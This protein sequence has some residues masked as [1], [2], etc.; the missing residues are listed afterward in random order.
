[1]TRNAWWSPLGLSAALFVSCG[2]KAENSIGRRAGEAPSTSP[3]STPD[4]EGAASSGGAYGS[5]AGGSSSGGSFPTG[6]A[7]FAGGP[8][9]AGGHG[10]EPSTGGAGPEPATPPWEALYGHYDL[11][12]FPAGTWDG[13]TA[14]EQCEYPTLRHFSLRNGAS[15][16]EARLFAPYRWIGWPEIVTLGEGVLEVR[17]GEQNSIEDLFGELALA[18]PFDEN[19][20]T[21]EGIAN[22]RIHCADG[23]H[24]DEWFV[25]LFEDTSPP[26][27]LPS[28]TTGGGYFYPFSW[29]YF[30][31]SEPLDFTGA[32]IFDYL[33]FET[34]EEAEKVVAYR[35]ADSSN[36]NL[37]FEGAPLNPHWVQAR[38][39]DM[40]HVGGTSGAFFPKDGFADDGG[41]A[42]VGADFHQT[43]ADIGAA[44]PRHDFDSAPPFWG[45]W[46]PHHV[47]PG[48]D[49][50]ACENGGGCVEVEM[51]DE[52]YCTSHEEFATWVKDGPVLGMRVRYRLFSKG[53][54]APVVTMNTGV[55]EATLSPDVTA[56]PLPHGDY[57]HASQWLTYELFGPAQSV[58]PFGVVFRLACEND[59]SPASDAA[60]LVLEWVEAI[61]AP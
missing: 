16:I 6:G 53:P 22:V 23:E 51:Y 27:L 20:F 52:H 17:I 50:S 3:P 57:T 40:E 25:S 43:I 13:P 9:S 7:G 15:G 34:P 60:K 41:N 18:L 26:V 30:R 55:V 10:N 54:N 24:R 35:A 21:G 42:L 28:P 32:S 61:P 38:F 5:A 31:L 37:V 11:T 47:A 36:V 56:L 48:Q 4:G 8:P 2:G 19:G 44:L 49:D 46:E 45:F 14:L 29:I 59:D 12:F 1:M 58:D 33:P 39:L